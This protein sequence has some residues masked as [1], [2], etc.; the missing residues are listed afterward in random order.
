MVV[1]SYSFLN[2]LSLEKIR[3]FAQKK[4]LIPVFFGTDPNEITNILNPNSGSKECKEAID[5]LV[6][7]M[8]VIGDTVYPKLLGF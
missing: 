4:N 6:K 5:G 8:R 3:F 2:H 1:S 7:P